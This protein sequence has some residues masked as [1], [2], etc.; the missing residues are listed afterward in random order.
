[1]LLPDPRPFSNDRDFWCL[2]S[3]LLMSDTQI[4]TL[5][6]HSEAMKPIDERVVQRCGS[7]M[8]KT[9]DF[10]MLG[11]IYLIEPDPYH[12]LIIRPPVGRPFC[13][14]QTLYKQS[15]SPSW[16]NTALNFPFVSSTP[17]YIGGPR[18]PKKVKACNNGRIW[19]TSRKRPTSA[20]N[21]RRLPPVFPGCTSLRVSY[22]RWLGPSVHTSRTNP[23]QNSPSPHTETIGLIQVLLCLL[24]TRM[25]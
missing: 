11:N 10:F 25:R 7:L 2:R 19:R 15:R 22:P 14:V 1:M 5:S 4:V 17:F 16:A 21:E 13:H 20:T 3:L 23:L 12:L 24:T 8:T 9:S 6:D 18:L